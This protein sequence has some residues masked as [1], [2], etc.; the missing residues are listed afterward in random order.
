MNHPFKLKN[1]TLLMALAAIYP[2]AAYSAA[3]VAQ[4][5]VGD[6]SVRRGAAAA[7]LAKGQSIDSGDSIV[8]GAAGQAQIRFSDGGLVS[9]SP[10]SQFNIDKYGDTNDGGADSFAV[11][12]LRGSMRAIT[13]L[14][15]KRSRDNYKITTNTATI[16]I[17]GSALS[18][19]INPDGTMDVAGE[20]DGIEVCTNAGC[21][22]LIVGEVVRVTDSNTL[23][24][25]TSGRSNVAP[26]VARTDL[27]HTDNPIRENESINLPDTSS[28]TPV[29][30]LLPPQVTGVSSL[31][32]FGNGPVDQVPRGG[33]APSSGAGT[34]VDLQLVKHVDTANGSLVEKTAQQKVLLAP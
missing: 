18:A 5:A 23:P 30:V 7:P 11:S 27:F 20:Q 3:G 34:F 26:L 24:T 25:R 9:L 32:A 2:V 22:G 8:T 28:N 21:V 6:V 10:N 19:K 15:G 33:Q 4:F 12:F 31:F 16:G 17:R 1:A 13:G 14:I 29:V